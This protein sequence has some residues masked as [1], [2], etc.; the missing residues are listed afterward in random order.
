[1]PCDTDATMPT[2]LCMCDVRCHRGPA[3]GEMLAH[4]DGP[5]SAAQCAHL[6]CS[7]NQNTQTG[8]TSVGEQF[9][10]MGFFHDSCSWDEVVVATSVPSAF[11]TTISSGVEV[12]CSL[13]GDPNPLAQCAGTW[14]EPDD[15]SGCV[16]MIADGAVPCRNGV[17]SSVSLPP[18]E[19]LTLSASWRQGSDDN[20]QYIELSGTDSVLLLEHDFGGPSGCVEGCA[21]DFSMELQMK[22]FDLDGSAAQFKL[23]GVFDGPESVTGEFVFEGSCQCTFTQGVFFGNE[24][25]TDNAITRVADDP[26][27]SGFVEGE[28]M[29]FR[30]D[31]RGSTLEFWA[32]ERLLYSYDTQAAISEMGLRPFRGRFQLYDWQ[33]SAV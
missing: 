19:G 12:L 20:G 22:L 24:P 10:V 8:D 2:A 18:C 14:A 17:P 16:A 9:L 25:G 5:V 28:L 26:Q 7:A 33:V 13:D 27:A 6:L 3:A 32:S 4:Y 21:S 30:V 11:E 23:G 29:T 1:M 15:A 31:R